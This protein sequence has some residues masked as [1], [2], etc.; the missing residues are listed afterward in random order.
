MASKCHFWTSSFFPFSPFSPFFLSSNS[1]V[2]SIFFFLLTQT[3]S[4]CFY[5]SPASLLPIPLKFSSPFFFPL[6]RHLLQIFC[7]FFLHVRNSGEEGGYGGGSLELLNPDATSL[8]TVFVG[9]GE[10]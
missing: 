7:F 6:P 9:G 4:P 2:F 10:N 3:F 5:P 8:E 1:N